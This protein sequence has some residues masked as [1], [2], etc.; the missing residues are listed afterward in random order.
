[1]ELT[2]REFDLLELLMKNPNRVYSRE[3]LLNLVWGYEYTGSTA[4]WTSISAV[5]GKGWS[6]TLPTRPPVHQMGGGYY[7]K[8]A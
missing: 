6:K 7:F 5:C 1:M 4:R 2:A 3:Q 8:E